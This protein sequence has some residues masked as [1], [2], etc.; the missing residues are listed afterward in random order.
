MWLFDYEI[1]SHIM[2]CVELGV[3]GIYVLSPLF[4]LMYMRAENA[5]AKRASTPPAT[6]PSRT[7]RW[8]WFL[9]FPGVKI[10]TCG[11]CNE[12][13][14]ELSLHVNENDRHKFPDVLKNGGENGKCIEKNRQIYI[15]CRKRY[16]WSDIITWLLSFLGLVIVEVALVAYYSP[17]SF[18][19]RIIS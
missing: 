19:I 17:D 18:N 5:M 10:V 12:E 2:I 16:T 8:L 6:A 7:P 14:L 9:R 3:L 13:L 11:V 15:R 1:S 4:L